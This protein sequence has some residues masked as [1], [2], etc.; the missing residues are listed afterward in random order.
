[1][2]AYITW[3]PYA[4]QLAR[5]EAKRAR[6]ETLGAVRHGPSLLAGVLVCGRCHCRMQGRSGGPRQLQ[7]STC[8]RLATTD[9]GDYGQ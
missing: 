2:P 5:L 3:A 8:H 7:S 4:H 9:G 6:A 1:M